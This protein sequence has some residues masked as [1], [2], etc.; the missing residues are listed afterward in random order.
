MATLS[1]SFHH[2]GVTN[3]EKIAAQIISRC[4]REH[5]ADAVLRDELKRAKLPRAESRAVAELVFLF[6]RWLGWLAGGSPERQFSRARELQARFDSD[7]NSFSLDEL[8]RAVPEWISDELELTR[9]WL[10]SLQT[11]P[12]LWL[13]AKR[14]CGKQL[15][16][17]LGDCVRGEN[18]FSDALEYRGDEDLFRTREFQAGD[19]EVQDIA[20]QLV[21]LL[22]NPKPGETWWDA[23]AGEGGKLLHLSDLM[24]NKGMIWASDRSERRLARLKQR[25]ARAKVFNYRIAP[26]DGSEKLPTKTKF[27][28]VLI[29]AP[30]SGVGTWQR[31]P[32]ARWTTTVE[33]V[34]ELSAIQQR[35]IL[36]AAPAVK[37]G[38][39]L[40]Y[41]VCTLT[42]SETDAVADRCS[43][44]LSGF[45]PSPLPAW[46]NEPPGA[47]AR[48]WI[49]PQS[50]RGNGMF[51][52]EWKR[53]S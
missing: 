51:V 3:V 22:C 1:P 19:F 27:D 32:H 8:K 46:P 21:G 30:C 6:F 45:A 2:R 42:R 25:A 44:Q 17:A 43:P 37:P 31:N 50:C 26:W 52:T 53:L 5:P 18:M 7:P 9:D 15:A 20:S 13:R 35:L 28:G 24:H 11:P 16:N 34:R 47:S 12:A 38:G 33:D 4:G 41:A 48:K 49:W 29:D 14:G 10:L 23:C 39:K 36:N 40:I